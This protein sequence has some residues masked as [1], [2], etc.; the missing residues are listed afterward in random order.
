MQLEDN[1]N[2]KLIIKGT[3]K[4]PYISTNEHYKYRAKS[5]KK[6]YIIIN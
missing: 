1:E 3:I 2:F 6:E 5:L 4:I